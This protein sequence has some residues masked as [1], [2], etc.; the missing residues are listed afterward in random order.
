M[1]EANDA[2]PFGSRPPDE[3]RGDALALLES[4]HAFVQAMFERFENEKDRATPPE[5]RALAA[6]ICRALTVHARIEEEIFYPAVREA[7][8]D[9]ADLLDEAELEHADAK[10]LIAEI[11]HDTEGFVPRVTLLKERTAHHVE[12]EQDELFPKVRVT[13][14]D[15][16]ALGKQL[17]VRKKELMSAPPDEIASAA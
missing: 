15:L 2:K 4:D 10:D 3:A 6:A 7:C 1:P 16:D 14:L 5:L 13:K 8:D 9:C 12:E 17:E 11:E